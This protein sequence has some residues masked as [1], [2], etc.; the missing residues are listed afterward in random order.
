MKP[1]HVIM[2]NTY[3][4]PAI[5]AIFLLLITGANAFAQNNSGKI[6]ITGTVYDEAKQPL[7]GASVREE[8]TSNGTITDLNGDFTIYVKKGSTLRISFLGLESKVMTAN[9]AGKFD[10]MLKDNT[11]ELSQVVV[12][13]YGKTTKDRVTGSVGVLTAEDLKGSPTANIDQLLRGKL[14]GVNVQMVSGRPGESAKIRIRGTKT[15]TGNA[16]PLWVIDGVPLQRNI[17]KINSNQV[18][19]GDFNNIYANGIAGINPNEIESITVLKDASASA[20]YGSEA[21]GGVIVVTTKRG[22]PGNLQINYSA[23]MTFVTKPPRDANLMNSQ[24][25]LAWEQEL[26]DEFGNTGNHPIIGIVG[27]IRSGTEQFKGMSRAEQDAYIEQLGKNSTDWFNELFRTSISQDH[28]ISFSGG[29]EKATYYVS[30]GYNSNKGL[31]LKSSADR[32]T[33]SAK[34]GLTINKRVSLDA[35][36][37][38]AL[39]N[40][41]GA[42]LNV[43]PFTYAY[44]ANPYEKPY[45]TDGSYCPDETYYALPR[46]NGTY[47]AVKPRNGFNIFRELNETSSKTRNIIAEVNANLKIDIWKGLSFDGLAA[48]GYTGNM[49]DNINGANTYAAFQDRQFEGN[50]LS[51]ERQYGSIFQSTA[52][53]LS[54]TLRG[55]LNYVRTFN[56]IHTISMIA[57]SE[58]SSQYAKNTFEKRYGYDEVTGNSSI[59]V[60]PSDQ[61][62][63]YN[64]LVAYGTIVDGLSGQSITEDAKASFFFTGDY[65]LM[66]KYVLSFT[67]RTDGSN[68]FGSKEQFQ[69]TGSLGLRWNI[70]EERFME[71]L[72][73][74]LSSLSIQLSGGYTGKINATAYPQVIMNYESS[75]RKSDISYYRMGKIANPPNPKLR[76]EKTFDMGASINAVFFNGRLASTFGFYRARSSDLVDQVKVPGTTGFNIQYY[77]T[78]V[79]LNQGVEISLSGEIIKS[80]DFSMNISTN[81]SYNLNKLVTYDSP[82]NG[83]YNKHEGYPLNSIFT[84]KYTGI[85]PK[86]GIYT[87][88]LR[89]DTNKQEKDYK[90]STNNY[91]FY[92]GTSNAPVTGGYTVD[93]KYKRLALSVGGTF[94]IG[95]KI[96]NNI[97]SPA[98]YGSIMP[99]NSGNVSTDREVV[100]TSRNDLYVNHLNV[101][102]KVVNRWTESNP[103]TN[104]YP[105]LIDAYG[106]KI[107][108]DGE[109]LEDYMVTI[110]TI[111]DG[112]LI[113]NLSYFKIGDIRLSYSFSEKQWMR[114]AHI[115]SLGISAS[116]DNTWI[117]SNYSG[118]D[119][120]TPG[121][122]YPQART[123]TLGLNIGF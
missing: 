116:M 90:K 52:Y 96:K 2:K 57:G 111:T 30:G 64:K 61:K 22:K 68:N 41:L 91:L 38:L 12:T 115:N 19:T 54:Y 103:V 42:S 8:K 97:D 86:W 120:E 109:Y 93:F 92:I 49:A 81:L 94:S 29:S 72:K 102:R 46:I 114:K 107:I 26:W 53:N 6:K 112:A 45:N 31:V 20:I 123:F 11:K 58:I 50:A 60:Y 17:P 106:S 105:R 70:G 67:T 33:I 7:A 118:I 108:I 56:K 88:K 55:K 35:T 36:T 23:Q 75:F 76:W 110:N 66:N 119:P 18:A 95:G 89:D 101:S 122:V 4:Y 87:F 71:K 37:N 80:R 13:G 77:N 27:M 51:S 32:Y 59:P 40:S 73:P 121:A 100:P 79:V 113:E 5:L 48:Y 47:S 74:A 84:G 44:F 1:K 85:D 99:A 63:D 34:V 82:F 28:N 9:I 104:G 83:Y 14:A 78:S 69:P 43:D 62:V 24:E 3:W 25:K 39:Q 98:S 21:A 10:I 117:I 16:E 65:V 15:V